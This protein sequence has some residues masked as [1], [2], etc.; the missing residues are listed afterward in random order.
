MEVATQMVTFLLPILE[1]RELFLPSLCQV[2]LRCRG[3]QGKQSQDEECWPE[4]EAGISTPRQT[5]AYIEQ[6]ALPT[7]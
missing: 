5:S 3:R 4:V 7:C 6:A 2:N 1:G